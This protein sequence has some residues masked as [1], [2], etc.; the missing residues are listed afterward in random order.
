MVLSTSGLKAKVDFLETRSTYFAEQ[1]MISDIALSS[2]I[3][4]YLL[5][6]SLV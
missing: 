5:K 6:D 1:Y 2:I 4:S 3:S